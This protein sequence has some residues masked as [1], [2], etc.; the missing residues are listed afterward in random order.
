MKRGDIVTAVASGDYGKPR[1][2]LVVQSD[3]LSQLNSVVLCLLTS[4]IDEE[5]LVRVVVEPTPVNGLERR[6]QVMIDKVVALDR[7]RCGKQI[8]II[9]GNTLDIVNERL[10][11]ALG[12][13]D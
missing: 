7:K 12:L 10:A 11:L 13:A 9:E 3:Q 4:D 1:P 2:A 8:G 6:S 5:N